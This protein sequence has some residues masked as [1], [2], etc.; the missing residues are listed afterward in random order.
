MSWLLFGM[1]LVSA[2]NVSVSFDSEMV[3]LLCDESATGCFSTANPNFFF[4]REG[5]GVYNAEL[6]F[7][8]EL[9]HVLDFRRLSEFERAKLGRQGL[10][11]RARNYS[12]EMMGERV[13]WQY[14]QGLSWFEK[15][16]GGICEQK[17][18]VLS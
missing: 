3:D 9:G 12:Y 15:G 1:L 8:H 18:G 13:V 10:E 6:T 2:H 7:Y 5:L 16:K 11:E 14:C 4:V 17:K